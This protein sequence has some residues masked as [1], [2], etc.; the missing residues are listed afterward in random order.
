M[1]NCCKECLNRELGCHS[2]CNRYKAHRLYYNIQKKRSIQM[3]SLGKYIY[4]KNNEYSRRYRQ[5]ALCL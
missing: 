1:I 5:R 4:N 2:K 3:I